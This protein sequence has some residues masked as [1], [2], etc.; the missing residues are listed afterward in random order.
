MED[1]MWVF[2]GILLV[3]APL[4]TLALMLAVWVVG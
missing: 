1:F 2:A 3:C 4:V